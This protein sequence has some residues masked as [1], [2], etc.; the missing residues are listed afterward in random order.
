MY[1]PCVEAVCNATD[2]ASEFYLLFPKPTPLRPYHNADLTFTG[3]TNVSI[4]T[5]AAVGGSGPYNASQIGGYL[6]Y[7]IPNGTAPAVPLLNASASVSV[8][9]S[10]SEPLPTYTGGA[11]GRGEVSWGVVLGGAV[12]GGAVAMGVGAGIW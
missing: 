3:F 8:S 9:S 1:G 11:A 7:T 6:N 5:C 4:A 2:R 10:T 12:L